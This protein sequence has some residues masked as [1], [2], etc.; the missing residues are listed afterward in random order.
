MNW[1]TEDATSSSSLLCPEI[2]T[3]SLLVPDIRVWDWKAHLVFTSQ[4]PWI[5]S[6]AI[7]CSDSPKFLFQNLIHNYTVQYPTDPEIS[8]NMQLEK[9]GE[10][11]PATAM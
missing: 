5:Q 1:A 6:P 11:N 10:T 4:A 7:I 8:Y 2:N 9:V 3:S